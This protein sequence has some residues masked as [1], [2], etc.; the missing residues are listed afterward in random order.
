MFMGIDCA[1]WL[2]SIKQKAKVVSNYCKRE[3]FGWAKLAW[4]LW[5]LEEHESF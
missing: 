4:L 2:D 1:I 3:R 5:F